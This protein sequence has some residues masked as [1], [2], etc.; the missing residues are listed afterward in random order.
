MVEKLEMDLML[1][2]RICLSDMLHVR[3][4]A[5]F[6]NL[7]RELIGPHLW[8]LKQQCT[9]PTDRVSRRCVC[10]STDL[11]ENFVTWETNSTMAVIPV[12]GNESE[13]KITDSNKMK[14]ENA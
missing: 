11:G 9:V 8:I 1:R 14:I 2:A 3:C 6:V 13:S 5:T 4:A 7:A 12:A 10:V